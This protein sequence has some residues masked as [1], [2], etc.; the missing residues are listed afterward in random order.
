MPGSV[1][2]FISSYGYWAM[3]IGALIEGET[4][5]IV[6]GIAAKHGI[7][8]LPGLIGMAIVGSYLH[9]NTFFYLGRFGGQRILQRSPQLK[10]QADKGMSLFERYGVWMVLGC[11]FFYGLRTVVPTVI[12]MS[13]MHT[14]VFMLF[15]F[16]GACVWSVLFIVGGYLFGEMIQIILTRLHGYESIMLMVGGGVLVLL[17]LIY[18]YTWWRRRRN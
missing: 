5:L 14:L 10:K 16:I 7:L 4:F 18:F 17:A 8:G 12:G 13:P 1:Q 15:S 2:H 11:R 3:F 6:G 9:D